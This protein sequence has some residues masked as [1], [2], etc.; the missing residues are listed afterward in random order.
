MRT[1]SLLGLLQLAD[2]LCPVGGFAH[3]FGL[4]T[5]AQAGLLPDRAALEALIAAHLEGSAGP[6]DAVAVALAGRLASA[7]TLDAICELDARL[8]ATKCVAEWREASRQMGRQAARLASAF[9]DDSLVH[10]LARRVAA[11]A[12]PG[13]H[14]VVFGTVAGGRG[15]EPE[16][17]AA[18]Y[19]HSTAALLV[20]AALRLAPIGQLDG[21]RV[22]AEMHSRIVRLAAVAAT[23]DLD[24]LWS[25]TPALELAGWRHARLDLRLFRS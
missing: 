9:T 4:E 1:A 17:A 7:G 19:L 6:S 23:A 25:F 20:N 18:A 8:D 13:H 15:A 2:G 3:S 10:E 12:T 14:A 5:Y 24:D 16:A 22:L 21:Q 11:R